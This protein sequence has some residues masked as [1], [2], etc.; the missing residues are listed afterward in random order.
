MDTSS[1]SIASSCRLTAD[2]IIKECIR[3][4][5]YRNPL[6]NEVLYLHHKG[7]DGIEP[8]AFDLYVNVKVLWLEGNGFSSLSCGDETIQV[9]PPKTNNLFDSEDD[10]DDAVEKE[11]QAADS[12]GTRHVDPMDSAAMERAIEES[13]PP[14]S[15]RY[16]AEPLPDGKTVPAEQKDVFSSLYRTVRQLYLHNNVF[17]LMPDISRFQ[18]LDSVN[19]SNNFFPT[20][21]P[22]CP[23]WIAGMAEHDAAEAAAL[24]SSKSAMRARQRL[25]EESTK[26]ALGDEQTVEGGITSVVDTDVVVIPSEEARVAREA[27]LEKYASLVD[28][29]ACFCQHAPLS[30]ELCGKKWRCIEPSQRN[31]CS[32]LR[33]LNVSGNHIE[34]FEDVVGLLCYKNLAVLDLSNNQIKDGEMLL[35]ILE[36]MTNL[37]S[38]KLSGNPLVRSLRRYRKTVVGRC[39]NLLHLDDRPIFE[40]ERRMVNAWT[41]GGDAA[42]ERERLVIKAEKEAK[43][44]KRLDD[45]RRLIARAQRGPPVGH[46]AYIEAITTR[47]AVAAIAR[48]EEQSS[49]TSSEEEEEEEEVAPTT[50]IRPRA[51]PLQPNAAFE[52]DEVSDEEEEGDVFIPGAVESS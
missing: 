22:C 9:A 35:L 25:E 19:L 50:M 34:S 11:A 21:R 8:S 12:A 46:E 6:C 3:Q 5:Y 20:I 26:S 39:R 30:T 31:P 1:T 41:D 42:E 2:A 17:R 14:K 44:R 38:L 49:A 29:F 36:R 24:T 37:S 23:Q 15:P 43:E 13:K 18:R 27:Q 51:A 32:S 45:F 16:P 52:E 7:F 33:T 40:D 10:D 28:K 4:G 48:E 47:E